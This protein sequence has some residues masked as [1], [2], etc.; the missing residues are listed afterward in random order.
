MRAIIEAAIN[1]AKDGVKVHPHIMIPLVGIEDELV[2]QAKIVHDVAQQVFAATGSKVD[3]KV[4]WWQGVLAAAWAGSVLAG[5][6]AWSLLLQT[7]GPPVAAGCVAAAFHE[8]PTVDTGGMN[9]FIGVKPLS[10]QCVFSLGLFKCCCNCNHC[11]YPTLK[12]TQRR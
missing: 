9:V 11:M 3:Y 12:V 6:H 2:G 8:L 10:R 5:R 7:A 1:V 4:G